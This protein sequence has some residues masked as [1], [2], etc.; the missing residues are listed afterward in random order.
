MKIYFDFFHA[1]VPKVLIYTKMI[2]YITGILEIILGL[3]LCFKKTQSIAS[4][5]I[6]ILLIVVFPANLYLYL[7]DVPR[8]FL[9]INKGQAILRLPFQ[10][11]LIIISYWH[12]VESSSEHFSRISAFL[13]V[14]TMAYF[15]TV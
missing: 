9:G 2:V 6:I 12:S 4:W 13:F 3:F 10:I 14:I 15:L 11:S 8:D 5:G 7:S 1:L